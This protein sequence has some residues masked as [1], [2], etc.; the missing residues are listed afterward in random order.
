MSRHEGRTAVITG[1]ALGLGRKFLDL[2]VAGPGGTLPGL[3]DR[4]VGLAQRANIR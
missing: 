4:V 3:L 1:T 2:V